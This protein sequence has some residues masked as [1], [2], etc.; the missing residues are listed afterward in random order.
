MSVRCITAVLDKSVH[1]GSKL[2]A[3]LVLADYS[4]DEGRSYPSMDSIA[5]KCRTSSRHANRLIEALVASGEL[6]AHQGKGPP[7][8]GGYLN[9]YRIRLEVLATREGVTRASGLSLS[10]GMT[11]MSP[12]A[13]KEMTPAP[14]L[15][16]VPLSEGVTSKAERGDTGV[17]EGMTPMSPKPSVNRQEPKR[18]RAR[19]TSMP[20][21]FGISERVRSWAT[22][23]DFGRLDEH[24]EA[25]CGKAL[26][27]GY[28]YLDWDQAFMNAI[29]ADWAKLNGAGA[30]RVAAAEK[31]EFV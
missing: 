14:S 12:P 24:L 7:V 19:E 13:P 20:E 27:K 22:E 28:T 10:E 6:E 26:A 3:M 16:V 18:E 17:L 4:D 23:K 31:V 11:P 15:S 30:A 5:R 8:R 9:L 21:D 2:L 29:R 25:F 1:A